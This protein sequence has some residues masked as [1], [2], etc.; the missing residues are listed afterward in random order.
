MFR[1]IAL[2]IVMIAMVWGCGEDAPSPLAPNTS[3]TAPTPPALGT[4]DGSGFELRVYREDAAGA[5]TLAWKGNALGPAL[6]S[7]EA[8]DTPIVGFGQP[9]RMEWTVQRDGP[10]VF[11]NAFVASQATAPLARP[12]LTND[13]PLGDTVDFSF[14]NELPG[15]LIPSAG[16]D[17]GPDC[18]GEHRL[19]SG[20]YRFD[21]LGTDALGQLR[22]VDATNIPFA[23]NFAPETSLVVNQEFPYY[24]IDDGQGGTIRQVFQP[25]DTIP[26]GAFVVVGMEGFDRREGSVADPNQLCCDRVLDALAA[27][28]TYQGLLKMV[29]TEGE[30]PIHYQTL[31]SDRD[32]E[33]TLGFLVGPF[34]YTVNARTVDE[35]DKRDPDPDTLQFRAGFDPSLVQTVPA[36]GDKLILRVPLNGAWPENDVPYAVSPATKYWDGLQYWTDDAPGREPVSGSI[37]RWT[38]SLQGAPDAREPDTEVRSWTYSIF[39]ERDPNNLYVDGPADSPDLSFYQ[40]SNEPNMR[41]LAGDDGIE[42]FVPT[43]LWFAPDLFDDPSA[44]ALYR[45]LGLYLANQIGNMQLRARG[46]TTTFGDDFKLYIHVVSEP[47]DPYINIDT[48]RLGRQTPLETVDFEIVLGLDPNNT[49]AVTRFWPDEST[50]PPG[51]KRPG[52]AR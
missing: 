21:V 31:Y 26:D 40:S 39:S 28:V 49:G 35:L 17:E 13:R 4:G 25:G 5:E 19:D 27:E 36:S 41:I 45:E 22:S 15:A 42:L 14:A 44:N 47:G 1:R 23:A 9:F 52:G 18:P 8:T 48:T 6:D 46:R 32:E 10:L 34:D 51:P 24:E 33:P 43:V 12:V 29:A 7:P 30:R 20:E 3:P 50:F 2:A 11:G 38:L 37:Y 16:C